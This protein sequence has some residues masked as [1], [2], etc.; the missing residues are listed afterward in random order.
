MR[1]KLLD[2]A[3][4]HFGR[5]GFEGAA[6]RAIAAAADTAM[7]QITYHFGGKEGL[8]LACADHIAARIS[9]WHRPRIAELG[10]LEALDGDAAVDAICHVISGFAHLMLNP[11]TKAWANFISR[12][13]QTPTEAFER[14][15][16]GAM[17]P[18]MDT[19]VALIRRARP[20]FSEQ[21]ARATGM[22]IWGQ[23][24]VLRTAR[25][26]VRRVMEVDEIDPATAALLIERLTQ[27]TRC[28]LTHLPETTR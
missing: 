19:G 28:L 13:Q 7:S 26:T 4:D 20:D 24:L 18:V 25:E 6:T 15:F 2:I 1:E 23:V 17:R 8:Y 21:E 27:H 16:N 10:D 11:A 9:D 3:I 22:L 12:E 14:L 5:R